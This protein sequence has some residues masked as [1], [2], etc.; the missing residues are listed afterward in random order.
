MAFQP[1]QQFLDESL[2]GGNLELLQEVDAAAYRV[3]AAGRKARPGKA[4][5][6]ITGGPDFPAVVQPTT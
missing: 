5:F 6:A 1:L 2:T 4:V 3:K